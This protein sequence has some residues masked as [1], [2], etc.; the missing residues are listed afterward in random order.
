MIQKISKLKL[1]HFLASLEKDYEIYAPVKKGEIFEFEKL[2]DDKIINFFES[3]YSSFKKLIFPAVDE[4]CKTLNNTYSPPSIPF[5]KVVFGMTASDIH[6]LN[7]LKKIMLSPIEDAR[8]ADHLKMTTFVTVTNGRIRSKKIITDEVEQGYDLLMIKIGD[9]YYFESSNP[10]GEKII[11]SYKMENIDI[12][13]ETKPQSEFAIFQDK[14][15]I[16]R[17]IEKSKGS[18]IWKDL[19]KIC[20]G[21]GNCSDVCP[22]CYCFDTVDKFDAG[23]NAGTRC[24]IWDSCFYKKFDQTTNHNFRENLEDRIYHF[25]HHK[26]VQALNERGDFNCNHCG[27]CIMACP[28]NIN[29]FKV[30]DEIL[31]K[32]GEEN[33]KK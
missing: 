2:T 4:I 25:F 3:S 5:K 17:A 19:A 11:S 9:N 14:E 15:K 24:R 20:L 13:V 18:H 7:S 22:L 16:A 1:N 33:A 32:F 6:A 8:F 27:R 28:V 10:K 12:E 26:F 30:L 29:I 21:C 23:N 31:I